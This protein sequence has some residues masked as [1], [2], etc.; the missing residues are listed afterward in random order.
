LDKEKLGKAKALEI[1]MEKRENQLR[2]IDK[3]FED[4][5]RE[6]NDIYYFS[7]SIQFREQ[8]KSGKKSAGFAVHDPEPDWSRQMILGVGILRELIWRRKEFLEKEFEEL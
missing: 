1:E 3:F 6:P 7:V 2:A 5:N 8:D 4:S